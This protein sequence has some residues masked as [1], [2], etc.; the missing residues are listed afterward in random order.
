MSET[1][2]YLDIAA[3]TGKTRRAVEIRAVTES[4][5]YTEER[6]RGGRRRLFPVAQLPQDIQAAIKARAAQA[7]LA[8][9]P[10]PPAPTVPALPIALRPLT[11]LTDRQRLERDA[12]AGVL[13][14]IRRLMDEAGC[15]QEA[16]MTTL[17][18]SA[19]GGRL[20]P[21][22]DAMLRL[23]RDPRGRAG[24]GY[25]SIR[26]LKRWL[27]AR[28][29]APRQPQQD[30][31]VP[32]W[33][34]AFLEAYQQPQKPTVAQ[35][36]REFLKTWADEA[37]TL[38][39]VRR[40]LDK[41]GRVSREMGRRG[42]RELKALKPFVRRGFEQ[43]LPNDVW[44]ADGHCFD[45]EVQHPLTGKAFRP[46]ITS[47]VDI[48]TRRCLGFS[49]DLAESGFAVL[50]A[51]EHAVERA[52]IPAIFYV[53]NG[54][55]YQNAM[56]R[57]EAVGL[58]G[59]L[60]ITMENSLPYNS[61][62]R[63][64]IERLHQTLWVAAAKK[65]P[66]YIGAAMDREARQQQFK[67]TRVALKG[68]VARL[69]LLPFA[70]FIAFCTEEV[71][72]YNARPHRSLGNKSPDQVWAEKV[73]DVRVDTLTPEE[74]DTLF[75]PRVE[76]TAARGEIQLFGNIYFSAALTEFHGETVQVAYDIHDASRV[77]VYAQDG[78]LICT[79]EWNANKRDYFPVPVVAQARERRADGRL[80]RKQNQIAEIEAER[81]ARPAL[82][83]VAG[84][85][86]LVIPGMGR[87]SKEQLDARP[88]AAV[89]AEPPRPTATAVCF[90]EAQAPVATLPESPEGKFRRW[91]ELN[92]LIAK[93]RFIDDE[94]EREF[95]TTYQL[96][97]QFAAQKRRLEGNAA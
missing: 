29:L 93:G 22:L 39:Q 23:A 36:Y 2:T 61:Q 44:S 83:V 82:E 8:R 25:P 9:L 53:D 59:R 42:P 97:K 48:A 56:M 33:A 41:V 26:T 63:G 90:T 43:L 1:V 64:V 94:Q 57:D 62:A 73:G 55:G 69:P 17:L 68:Q 95:Y 74:R 65:L 96:T 72:A 16:A 18:T 21:Q 4:W 54:S 32:A 27:K 15:S 77:W 20:E 86:P 71:A 6:V 3:A 47:I 24:N 13:K 37:P 31:S 34:H 49:V 70:E 50:Y 14:A 75:R 46:E 81:R 40:F 7:A 80:K 5:P 79:A 12:R 88:L 19:C 52:G 28:D 84:G 91:L 51:L 76:R 87:I 60:G 38:H 35:A 45:A 92:D 85:E 66:S 67:L 30:L 78:R 10:A 89:A 11:D 58:M